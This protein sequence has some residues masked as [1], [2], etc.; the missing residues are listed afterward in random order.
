LGLTTEF[1]LEDLIASHRRL[2]ALNQKSQEE[3][4]MEYQ[5]VRT[6]ACNDAK[7]Y[8]MVSIDKLR[9]MTL[10]ELVDLLES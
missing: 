4:Q 8:D 7:A 6:S 1:T 9:A 3:I 5:A 10:K 2:R